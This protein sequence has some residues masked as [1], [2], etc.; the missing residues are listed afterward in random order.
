[1]TIAAEGTTRAGQT[2]A[3]LAAT[4]T[5]SLVIVAYDSE[6]ILL[7]CLESL[8]HQDVPSLEVVVVN[9]GSDAPDLASARLER[10]KV[11]S[12]GRNLGFPAGCNLGAAAATGDILVFLNPDTV[13]AEGAL[14]ALAAT[15]EDPSIGIAQAR[16][17]LLR[18]PELLNTSGNV[19]HISGLAWVGNHRERAND[20]T[21]LRDVAF[22]SGAA[23]AIRADVFRALDGF[24]EELFLYQEDVDLGWR[25]RQ[26][27]LRVVVQPAADVYHDYSTQMTRQKLYY[28]ER[29]RL[30]VLFC[31]C[32]ARLLLVL[33]PI[34][35]VA[36]LGLALVAWRQGWL[37]E[38]TR[39]W[40]WCL[41]NARTLVR[42][43]R[44]TQRARRVPDR[45]LVD[46]LEV[47]LDRRVIAA[48]RVVALANPILSA[49]WS[50]ARRVL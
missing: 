28:I 40:G 21:E 43:R 41:R 20:A 15:L 50:L 23:M 35:T 46:L 8:A 49:Y 9:N 26:A 34:L 16:L 4:A 12:P 36:E 17:R 45:D 6:P 13:V 1:V 22:P 37:G 24:R 30:A 14:A 27:G 25:V 5:I 47:P 19:L 39:G 38:K 48:P 44:E 18:E 31:N 33:A 7:E 42:L 29:N 3:I 11:L 32:S 10:L 2:G